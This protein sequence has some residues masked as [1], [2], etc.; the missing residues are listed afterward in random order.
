MNTQSGLQ[1]NG[2]MRGEASEQEGKREALQ[3]AWKR[4]DWT[5]I[6]ISG[7]EDFVGPMFLASFVQLRHCGD[8]KEFA[9]EQFAS[10]NMS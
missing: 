5:L 9:Q 10:S 6:T 2:E 8:A 3:W 1:S 7:N 4:L